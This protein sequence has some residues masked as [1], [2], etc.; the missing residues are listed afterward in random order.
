MRRIGW[1][2]A[3]EGREFAG[4]LRRIPACEDSQRPDRSICQQSRMLRRHLVVSSPM[5][6]APAAGAA[7]GGA[8]KLLKLDR[9]ISTGFCGALDPAL[10]I[11]DIVRLG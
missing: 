7:L 2:M 8:A 6:P 3:A 5:D 4:I 9:M 11:G 10:Q 1:S